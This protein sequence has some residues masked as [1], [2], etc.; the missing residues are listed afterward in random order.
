MTSNIISVTNGIAAKNKIVDFGPQPL[1][2]PLAPQ[3]VG[4]MSGR[5]G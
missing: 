2:C 4:T 1:T 5:E 3:W